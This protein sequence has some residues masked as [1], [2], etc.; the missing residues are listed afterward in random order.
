MSG[1]FI[2]YRR[3]DAGGVAGRLY[4]YLTTKISR[5]DIFMDVDAMRPGMDF[6]TQL[7][8]SLSQCHVL[9]AMIGPHWL[10]AKDRNGRRRLDNNSD[11]V[12][13]ELSSALKRDIPVIPILIDGAEMPSEESLPVELSRWRVA[14]RL[15]C[16]TRA[17]MP[18]PTQSC[19]CWRSCRRITQ[20]RGGLS[21]GAWR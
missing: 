21:A 19:M 14:T 17:S 1:I 15:N 8:A 13:V 20:C 6:V 18:T 16:V 2:N 9:L 4:D 12:R 7:D 5:R 11:F 10:D 3:D